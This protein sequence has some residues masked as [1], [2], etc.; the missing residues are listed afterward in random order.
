MFLLLFGLYTIIVCMYQIRI[1]LIILL[2]E[3]QRI[4]FEFLGTRKI[5]IRFPGIKSFQYT[6]NTIEISR[7]LFCL[8]SAVAAIVEYFMIV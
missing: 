8:P 5:L 6:A 3:F 1:G 4:P 2:N 7:C